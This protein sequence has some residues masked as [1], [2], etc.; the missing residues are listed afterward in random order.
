[1]RSRRLLQNAHIKI[2]VKY[3]Q[4]SGLDVLLLL[5]RNIRPGR[6]ISPDPVSSGSDLIFI[7]H[8]LQ[9]ILQ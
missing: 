1:M 9:T 8:L 6:R 7:R 3:D 2:H 5:R 4:R